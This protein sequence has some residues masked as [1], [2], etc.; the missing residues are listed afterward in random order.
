MGY[1]QVWYGSLPSNNRGDMK[2][3]DIIYKNNN[4]GVIVEEKDDFITVIFLKIGMYMPEIFK[5][6]EVEVVCEN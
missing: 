5:K 2:V 6:D 1:G 4:R 3:G